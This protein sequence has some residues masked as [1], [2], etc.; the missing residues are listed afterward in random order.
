MPDHWTYILG[1]IG[2]QGTQEPQHPAAGPCLCCRDRGTGLVAPQQGSDTCVR[3]VRRRAWRRHSAPVL[4]A[5]QRE[6]G[7]W[8]AVRREHAA[9]AARP[10]R[11]AHA[12]GH[13]GV[14]ASN[15]AAFVCAGSVCGAC[16]AVQPLGRRVPAHTLVM[17]QVQRYAIRRQHIYARPPSEGLVPVTS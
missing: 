14:R 11:H 6:G 15:T 7:M 3:C 8:R 12:Q 5:V 2:G 13:K 4:R 10:R 9:G 17:R 1:V 16:A